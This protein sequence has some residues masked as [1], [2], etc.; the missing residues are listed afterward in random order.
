MLRKP[1]KTHCGNT[2]RN[3]TQKT[4]CMQRSMS[5][6]GGLSRNSDGR[7]AALLRSSRRIWGAGKRALRHGNVHNSLFRHGKRR[8]QHMEKQSAAF[9]RPANGVSHNSMSKAVI[10]IPTNPNIGEIQTFCK[11]DYQ[12]G[13]LLQKSLDFIFDDFSVSVRR[14]RPMS[15]CHLS[16][17]W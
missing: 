16:I 3:G 6:A 15:H 5:H 7:K 17:F 2:G 11:K 4:A 10:H 14:S 1:Q 13:F 8:S 12:S 9:P